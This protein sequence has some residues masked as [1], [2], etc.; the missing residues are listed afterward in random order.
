LQA[1]HDMQPLIVQTAV[2]E[3]YQSYFGTSLAGTVQGTLQQLCRIAVLTRT[4]VDK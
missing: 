3:I 2:V 4:S 1:K